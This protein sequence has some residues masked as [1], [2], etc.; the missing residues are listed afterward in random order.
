MFGGLPR[1]VLQSAANLPIIM[2]AGGNHTYSNA[3]WSRNDTVVEGG[4]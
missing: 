1:P 2:V 3:D 4:R